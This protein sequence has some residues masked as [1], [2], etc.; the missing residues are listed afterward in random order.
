M[1]WDKSH[2]SRLSEFGRTR[3]LTGPEQISGTAESGNEELSVDN[4][5][6]FLQK[7]IDG[8]IPPDEE[9]VKNMEQVLSIFGSNKEMSELNS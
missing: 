5:K 9:A 6:A 7:I 1:L 4:V 3:G 8:E 2:T